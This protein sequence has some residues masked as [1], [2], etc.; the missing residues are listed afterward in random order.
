[1]SNTLAIALGCFLANCVVSALPGCNHARTPVPVSEKKQQPVSATQETTASINDH[2][3]VPLPRLIGIADYILLGSVQSVEK[4]TF[5]FKTE[6]TLAGNAAE[7]VLTVAQFIPNK[8]DGPRDV[9]YEKG[10]RF[11]LFLKMD[12]TQNLLRVI[13]AGGEGEMPVEEGFV[14]FYGRYVEGLERKNYTVHSKERSIQ[15]FDYKIFG[16]AVKDFRRC[17]S[18]KFDP[19]EERYK[20]Q[21]ICGTDEIQRIGDKSFIHRYITDRAK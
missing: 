19:A 2:D 16:D 6:E 1:M 17:Y 18:C 15:R 9:P 5:S 21:K 10:Q 11:L 12:S 7:N 13:G 4:E 3:P 20:F 8:F 14:Y